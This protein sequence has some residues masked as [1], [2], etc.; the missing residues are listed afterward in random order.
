MKFHFSLKNIKVNKKSKISKKQQMLH[1]ETI[2][3][4]HLKQMATLKYNFSSSPTG[5]FHP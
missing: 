4:K 5:K 2:E 1:K 3:I